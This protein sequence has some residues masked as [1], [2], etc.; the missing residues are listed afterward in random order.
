FYMPDPGGFHTYGMLWTPTLTTFYVDGLATLQ[1]PTPQSWNS[2]MYMI[3]NL[4]LGGWGGYVDENGL[5]AQMNVD[6]GRAYGL[7]DGSSIAKNMAATNGYVESGTPTSPAAT[8]VNTVD[9]V[10]SHQTITG[11]DAGDTFISNDSGNV[12]IGGAGADFF[13]IGRGGDTV[14]GAGGAD[15]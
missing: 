1:L 8:G 14:T 10:G 2:P 6:Y 7:A 12:L 5:P 3:M 4:A 13:E 11:N 15:T 9:L